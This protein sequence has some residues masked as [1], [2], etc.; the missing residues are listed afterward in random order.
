[1]SDPTSSVTETDH[2]TCVARVLREGERPSGG[3]DGAPL[4]V[5]LLQGE[6]AAMDSTTRDAR[7]VPVLGD[8]A[9][10]CASAEIVE[11]SREAFAS[12]DHA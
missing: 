6:A 11:S 7:F 4:R 1:M 8:K 9:A 12:C 2:C 5:G 3:P 10:P